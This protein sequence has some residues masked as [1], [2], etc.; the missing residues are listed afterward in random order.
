MIL[1][2]RSSVNTC[3]SLF[4]SCIVCIIQAH[5]SLAS[6]FRV[7][8]YLQH[9]TSNGMTLIWFSNSDAPGQLEVHGPGAYQSGASFE[10]VPYHAIEL[11]YPTWESNRFFG[12]QNVAL[13]YARS[14]QQ[15]VFIPPVRRIIPLVYQVREHHL[16]TQYAPAPP[17]RH[18]AVFHLPQHIKHHTAEYVHIFV[19]IHH[20][21]HGERPH[22]IHR[23]CRQ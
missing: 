2:N 4:I 10:S 7:P 16:F 13:S 20:G 9:P 17:Y 14:P 21:A 23:V 18:R 8:P 5:P 22:S 6:D 15:P 3:L 12:R 19:A 1:G 11:S